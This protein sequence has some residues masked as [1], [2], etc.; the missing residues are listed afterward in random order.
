[1][2][3]PVAGENVLVFSLEEFTTEL[4]FRSSRFVEH[5]MKRNAFEGEVVVVDGDFHITQENLEAI[6]ERNRKA[7]EELRYAFENADEIRRKVVREMVLQSS[8]VS[9]E[10]AKRLGY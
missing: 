10:T 7:Q 8:G 3:T 1:M 4:G 2:S 9:E 5:L 6:K